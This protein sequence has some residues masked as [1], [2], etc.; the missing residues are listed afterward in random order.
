[1][2]FKRLFI[3]FFL[4]VTIQHLA[5]AEGSTDSLTRIMKKVYNWQWNDLQDNGWK[6]E[7]TDWTYGVMLAGMTDWAHFSHEHKYIDNLVA[8]GNATNW[9]LG[10]RRS[11]ADDYCVGQTY[12]LLYPA[13]KNPRFITDFR[14]MADSL[15]LAP[16]SESLLW[17]NNIH[18][19]QWAW[20]DAL[21]MGPASLGYLSKATGDKRYLDLAIR[22]WWKTTG[23]LYDKNE[24]LF[25]R[26]SR[27]FDKREKNGRKVF[28]SRGNGWVLAGMTRLL[29]SMP[30]NDVQRAQFIKLF[31]EM[32]ASVAALQ[33]PDGSW[34]AS[35]LDPKSYPSKETSGT[36]LFCYA[37]AWGIN[38]NI[39]SRKEYLPVVNKAWAVLT[40]SVHADGK[41]GYVQPVG[42]APDIVT[43]DDT[44]VYGVGAFLMAGV[45]MV[46]ITK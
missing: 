44:D 4:L 1:M 12:A 37:F 10:P 31:R 41:L 21:F 8:V 19:R 33:Q 6:R 35:L 45:Q 40:S 2:F 17:V 39:L 13:Y 30:E 18:L 15:V 11:F 27:Y 7:R 20:C 46:H 43:A 26:D 29:E 42:A 34:H 28:W 5:I 32:A 22:L 9:R 16:H 23:Y 38:H 14:K 25:Y 24:K 36:G 3:L